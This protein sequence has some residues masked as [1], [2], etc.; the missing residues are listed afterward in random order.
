MVGCNVYP[1]GFVV[2]VLVRSLVG[3]N[4]GGMMNTGLNS[5]ASSSSSSSSSV[6]LVLVLVIAI[7]IVLARDGDDDGIYLMMQF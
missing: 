4:V 6:V 7:A 3:F 5:S 1:T 2:V